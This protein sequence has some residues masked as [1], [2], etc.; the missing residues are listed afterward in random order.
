MESLE[1]LMSTMRRPLLASANDLQSR[2]GGMLG[3]RAADAPAA[4]VVP[5][6]TAFMARGA[7]YGDDDDARAATDAAYAVNSTLFCF[8][9]ARGGAGGSAQRTRTRIHLRA[10][11]RARA[12]PLFSHFFS[13]S[14]FPP[15]PPPSSFWA[16]WRSS[17]SASPTSP[18][19][20]RAR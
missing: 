15:L 2:L 19:A 12:D 9:E 3:L 8:G 10:N 7:A 17:A 13:L 18:A 20:P 6:L 11:A 16:C 14:P 4:P 1:E 5:F